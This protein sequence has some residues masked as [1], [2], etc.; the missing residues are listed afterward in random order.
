M[1]FFS[2]GFLR[3]YEEIYAPRV[4]EF[5]CITNNTYDKVEI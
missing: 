2:R 4:E 5:Y 1:F 3:K